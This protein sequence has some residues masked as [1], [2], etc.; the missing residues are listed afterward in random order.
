VNS[1]DSLEFN[2]KGLRKGLDMGCFPDVHREQF[3]LEG[4]LIFSFLA[5]LL[6]L[7]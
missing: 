7:F 6:V 3:I 4:I 5:G 1:L 2:L